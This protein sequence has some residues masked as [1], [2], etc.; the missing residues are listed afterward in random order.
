MRACIGCRYS[1]QRQVMLGLPHRTVVN[2]W[3]NLG[4]TLTAAYAAVN[5]TQELSLFLFR[6][7]FFFPYR[8]SSTRNKIVNTRRSTAT[9][10]FL[11]CPQ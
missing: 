3:S 10:C 6:K 11:F 1:E 5:P 8:N 9:Q 2:Y 7:I 4:V